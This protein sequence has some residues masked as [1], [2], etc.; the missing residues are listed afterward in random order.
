[1]VLFIAVAPAIRFGGT[2]SGAEVSELNQMRFTSC[3]AHTVK[4][5]LVN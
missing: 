3:V 2:P 5:L 1:M 4:A